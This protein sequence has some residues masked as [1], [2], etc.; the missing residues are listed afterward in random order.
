MSSNTVR[1]GSP[2]PSWE[3]WV[4]Q[5]E[6]KPDAGQIRSTPEGEVI[7][8]RRPLGTHKK[9]VDFLDKKRKPEDVGANRQ[10]LNDIRV[11]LQNRFN[12]GLGGTL[13]DKFFAHKS[14]KGRPISSKEISLANKL[15][16]TYEGASEALVSRFG[17]EGEQRIFE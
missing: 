1:G 4:S 11:S 17:R 3:A 10:S 9:K 13:F 15:G 8:A 16:K 6:K 5:A 14:E 7:R 2:G 12:R